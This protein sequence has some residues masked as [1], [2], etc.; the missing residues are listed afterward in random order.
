MTEQNTSITEKN[1][2]VQEQNKN[3]FIIL[4]RHSFIIIKFKY[5]FIRI[6][7]FYKYI[8]MNF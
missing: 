7:S 6:V 1:K 3:F 2:T 4:N 8:L 5:M